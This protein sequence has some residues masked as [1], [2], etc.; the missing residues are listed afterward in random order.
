M[1]KS[2]PRALGTLDL[3]GRKL[4]FG[5]IAGAAALLTGWGLWFFGSTVAVYAVSQDARLEVDRASYAVETPVGGRVVSSTLTMGRAVSAGEVLV[6]L[7]IRAQG[8]EVGEERA[9]LSGLG[10][11]LARLMAEIAE[12]ETGRRDAQ[13]ATAAAKAEALA[14]YEE[15][16]ATADLAVD[17]EKRAVKLAESGLIPQADLTRARAEAK[18]TRAA[19][20]TFRLA[21]LRIDADQRRRDTDHRIEIERLQREAAN[22]RA[23]A[24]TATATV[25]R[26]QHQGELRRILAPVAGTLAE[27]STLRVGRVLQSGD[28]V[29]TIVPSGGLRIVATF[30]PAEAFGRLRPGQAA[31]LRLDGFPFTQYGSVGARVSSVAS[32]VRDGKVP[33]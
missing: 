30:L 15:A 29:A 5:L 14:R 12:Q 3:E 31:R 23:Q 24:G 17:N 33:R 7:D 22:L 26:L 6:E 19:A 27:V 21:S 8:L 2:F 13:A 28:T 20:E 25:E 1:S 4:R 11:Q 18:Q 9:R 16:V 10:P 32:E